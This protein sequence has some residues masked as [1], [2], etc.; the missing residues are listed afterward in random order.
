MNPSELGDIPAGWRVG[1]LGDVVEKA[2]TGAEY[3]KEKLL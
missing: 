2:N 1:K 3:H